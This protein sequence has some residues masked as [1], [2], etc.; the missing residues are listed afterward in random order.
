[1]PFLGPKWSVLPEQNFVGTSH[2]YYFY[3]PISPFHCAKFKKSS[4]S[5][6][7]VMRMRHFWVENGPFAPNKKIIG[8]D[9]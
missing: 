4:Y 9:Y 8:K 7:R 3:I 2:Y 6:S 5:G 1:M